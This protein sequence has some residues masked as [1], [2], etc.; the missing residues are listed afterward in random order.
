MA[1]STRKP[2]CL[3]HSVSSDHVEQTP[4][5][6]VP[7]PKTSVG[8]DNVDDLLA[9]DEALS[10]LAEEDA[11]LA[12]LVELRYFTCLTIEETAKLLGVSPWTT[13][14]TGPTP[15]PGSN[16]R[17]GNRTVE[18]ASRPAVATCTQGKLPSRHLSW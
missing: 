9:L 17:W 1:T 6:L 4:D 2:T 18:Q 14:A 5:I 16:G 11:Q 3:C 12:K 10:K 13:N 7:R 15:V 8:S